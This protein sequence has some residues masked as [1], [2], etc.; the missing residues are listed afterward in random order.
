MQQE[1]SVKIVKPLTDFLEWKGW[2]VKKTH[3]N[4]FQEGFPDLFIS[5]MDYSPRWVECKVK[6]KGKSC[7]FTRSQR[8]DFPIFIRNNVPIYVVAAADLRG[9][10][11]GLNFAYSQI[12]GAPNAYSYLIKGAK[13]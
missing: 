13:F 1:E 10:R 4:Q 7:V 9:D 5:H 2:F 11:V 8:R 12:L 3:G 6:R